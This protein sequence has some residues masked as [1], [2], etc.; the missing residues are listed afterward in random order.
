M[1]SR[2]HRSHPLPGLNYYFGGGGGGWGV[3]LGRERNRGLCVVNGF[4]G[5]IG[6]WTQIVNKPHFY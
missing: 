4:S 6:N 2:G 5:K 3:V 1:C